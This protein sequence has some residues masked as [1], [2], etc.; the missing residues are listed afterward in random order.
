MQVKL[1]N[2]ALCV[3]DEISMVGTSTFG[4][5]CSALKKIKQ[6]TNDWGGVSILAVGDFFQLPPVGQCQVFKRS[7]N[8][9]TPGDLAPLLWDSFL[10]HDLTEVMRQKD[11]QFSTAL[12]NIRM[13]V[14]KEGS[15]EDKMLQSCE[16]HL[17]PSDNS[18]PRDAMHVYAQN[19]YCNEWNKP[20]FD[21]LDSKLY[22]SVA[23]DFSKDR[24][25]NLENITFPS[26]PRDTGNLLSVLNVKVGAHVMLTTNIDVCDGLT[27]GVMVLYQE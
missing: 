22:S 19:V 16:L 15:N 27:S 4:K 24:S 17:L 21:Q 2:L 9:H 20:R 7:S 26:N 25:T 6:S 1:K 3:I 18:Y 11:I 12:N 5:I 10:R 23:Q 8:V 14:P 13:N